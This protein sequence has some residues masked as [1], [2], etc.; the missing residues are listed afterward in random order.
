MDVLRVSLQLGLTSFGGPIAH[1]GYFERTYVRERRWLTAPE[2]AE[3]LALCQ[4]IPGPAS[5][6]LGFLIGLQRAGYRGAVAAW[7]GFTLPSAVLLYFAARAASHVH[8]A[9]ADAV[10]HGLKLVAVAVVAQAFWNL[11]RQ[12]WTDRTTVAIGACAAGLTLFITA[13]GTSLI[14]LGCAAALGALLCRSTAPAREVPRN[15]V[16]RPVAWASG[17][18]FLLLLLGLPVLEHGSPH[19]AV[20][21]ADKFYRAGALVF[22]GGHV[23]LPLLHGALVPS[24]WLPEDSFLAGYGLAQAVP[25]PLFTV[26]AYLGATNAFVGPPT[27]AASIALGSIFLPGLLLALAAVALWKEFAA[28]ERVRG[29]LIGVNAAVVGILG[30]ALY[31]PV[32][33]TSVHGV[34]D[35]VLAVLGLAMLAWWRRA[36]LWVVVVCVT[37]SLLQLWWR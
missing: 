13:P 35:G 10:L 23:V 30:A 32:L 22:G 4:I 20:A 16:S 26:A 33:I 27:W 31:N 3:L 15:V 17:I 18:A 21:L 37:G 29:A 5:S 12:M 25:G 28:H 24:G 6:Q 9:I 19:G 11:A 2:Y 36:P 7:I 14:A 1:L 8:G 34:A